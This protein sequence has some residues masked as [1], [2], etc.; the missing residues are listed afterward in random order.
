MIAAPHATVTLS[1]R[2]LTVIARARNPRPDRFADPEARVRDGEVVISAST[3][4]GPLSVTSVAR[5]RVG[6]TSATGGRPRLLSDV[7]AVEFGALSVPGWAR[8]ALDPRGGDTL[9]LDQAFDA[10]PALGLL[11][12]NLDCLAV[13][14]G[15]VRIGI[16][17]PGVTAFPAGCV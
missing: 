15:G 13:G 14:G 16:H 9:E 1:E 8:S 5:I 4:L 17:R 3:P 12:D 2:D 10:S 6:L 7:T 11:R